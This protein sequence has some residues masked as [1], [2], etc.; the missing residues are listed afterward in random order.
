MKSVSVIIPTYRDWV[1]LSKCLDALRQQTYPS[2]L[3]QIIV[4]NNDPL[5]MNPLLNDDK[6]NDVLFL[7]ES[8][9]G[10]YAARNKGL[11]YANGEVIAF[12]DSDC[13]PDGN[14]IYN[15]IYYFD[16]NSN[17]LRIGGRIEL[18]FKN[19]VSKTLAEFYEQSYAFRQSEFVRRQ[20]MAATANMFAYK[21]VFDEISVFDESLMSGGDAEWGRRAYRRGYKIIYRDN[22]IVNH[23]ARSSMK[24]IF[25]KNR[26]EAG[27]KVRSRK[28]VLINFFMSL[29]PPVKSFCY[30]RFRGNQVHKVLIAFVIRYIMR[31]DTAI[32]QLKIMFLKKRVE[33]L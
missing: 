24:Q 2:E 22:V 17:C 26:R 20:G 25:L 14:W 28:Q 7:V 8:K 15:A 33:R 4:I 31:I 29:F 23:P 3:I 6:Y 32:E 13:I 11:K 5:D 9:P 21:K 10:S 30:I 1:R 16:T 27:G 12:T 19:G 18:F